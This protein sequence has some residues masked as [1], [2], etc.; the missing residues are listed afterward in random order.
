MRELIVPAA[1]LLLGARCA[2]CGCS[3]LHL[4]RACGSRI[5]PQ[6]L[7]V[8]PDPVPGVLRHPTPVPPIASG[9]HAEVLR[10][11]VLAWKEEGV[12]RLTGVLAH[13]LA[14]SVVPHVRAGRGIVLVPVPTSRRSR[15][16]RGC[17]LVD[18][19]ARAA[20]DLLSDAGVEVAVEQ[21]LTYSR[22]TRD[23]AGLGAEARWN[24]LSGAF[25]VRRRSGLAGDPVVVD[26]VLTTGATAGEAVRA[27]TSA[28]RRPVGISVVASTARRS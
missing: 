11:V 5:R 17:D 27:L 13:H 10:R 7:V 4:C 25:A 26:D 8:W 23:Q 12:S 20:A 22:S 1:D 14:A 6:P 16:A 9:A 24:N 28:G 19:L 3:A 21:A 18:D 15:R 2:G